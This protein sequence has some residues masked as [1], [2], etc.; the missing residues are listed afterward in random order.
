MGNNSQKY[1]AGW[2]SDNCVAFSRILPAIFVSIFEDFIPKNIE[3]EYQRVF[4]A[5]KMMLISFFVMICK[6]MS[7][8]DIS[9]SVLDHHIWVFLNCCHGLEEDVVLM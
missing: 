2:L 4:D 9:V 7:L 5:L 8:D 1:T 6:L 3:S